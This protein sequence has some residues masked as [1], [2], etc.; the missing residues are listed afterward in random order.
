MTE[1]PDTVAHELGLRL[2]RAAEGVRH[3][4]REASSPGDLRRRLYRAA[5]TQPEEHQRR[6]MWS[7]YHEGRQALREL[8]EAREA[9]RRQR[10]AWQ[11]EEEEAERDLGALRARWTPPVTLDAAVT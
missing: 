1:S 7:V 9:G 8:D 3:A 11:R 6:V 10:D 2:Q 5:T 4:V